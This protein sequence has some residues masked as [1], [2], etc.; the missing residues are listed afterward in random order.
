MSLHFVCNVLLKYTKDVANLRMTNNEL[1]QKSIEWI[2]FGITIATVL[3]FF[4]FLRLGTKPTLIDALL[5]LDHITLHGNKRREVGYKHMTR[6]LVWGGFM[7]LLGVTIPLI[8]YH[9]VKRRIKN[10]FALARR[11]DP[12][13]VKPILT[14]NTKCAV[15]NDRPT[16]PHH[17]NCE[18]IFCYYCLQ[19]LTIIFT[20]S[21]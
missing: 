10:F 5:G 9:A 18:H 19:V 1:V 7:E 3:N 4:R 21:L 17:M 6:E 14:I 13:T 8:N 20:F 12:E 2:Q 11:I 16:Q 15:C